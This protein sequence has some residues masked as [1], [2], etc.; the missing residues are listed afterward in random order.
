MMMMMMMMMTMTTKYRIKHSVICLCQSAVVVVVVLLIIMWWWWDVNDHHH[1]Y[2]VLWRIYSRSFSY[3]GCVLTPTLFGIFSSLLL[4]YPFDSSTDGVYLHASTEG[5]LF[6]LARLCAKTKVKTVF[7][8]E[9]LFADN[10]YRGNIAE[11]HQP[12]RQRMWK[13]CPLNQSQENQC[14]FL[15]CQPSPWN[16]N[17][18][19]HSRGSRQIH[20]PPFHRLHEHEQDSEISRR[21]TGT[22]SKLTK[23][24][25]RNKYLTE[26]TNMH[27]YQ[28]CVL[29]KLFHG[30]ETWT[31]YTRQKHRLNTFYLRCL[32]RILGVK[33]QD[34]ITNSETLSRAEAQACT[35]FSVSVAW[36]GSG[37]LIA[38]T[39]DT[40]PTKTYTDNWRQE[41]GKSGALF[42]GSRTRANVTSKNAKFIQTTLKMPSVIVPAGDGQ[43]M[44]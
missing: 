17:R 28:E 40:S 37:I 8:S 4:S 43:R 24:A 42:C 36:D 39:M 25:W 26:R 5:K 33:W 44:R 16:Q 14:E 6:N 7:V 18:R 12:I 11:A 1:M 15:G 34:H 32:R 10:A 30:S 13:L 3:Q 19:P 2:R 29:S 31:T 20:L 22:M 23:R 21:A 41:S 35:P 38:W 9:M 27:M